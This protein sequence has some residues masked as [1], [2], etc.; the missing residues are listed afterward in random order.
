[1]QIKLSPVATLKKFFGT[2]YLYEVSAGTTIKDLL[3]EY[4]V[5]LKMIMFATA[6]KNSVSIQYEINNGDEIVLYPFI[7]G[8]I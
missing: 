6:N 8:G 2:G 4:N 1:M 3:L 7:S 5:P